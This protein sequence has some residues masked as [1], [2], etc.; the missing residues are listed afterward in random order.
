MRVLV[1]GGGISPE[2]EISLKSSKNVFDGVDE[3]KYQ[4]E[5]YDWDG[6]ES[7]LSQNLD[8]FDVVADFTRCWW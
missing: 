7:W 8:R 3:S 4:K 6:S 5:F 1:I 2:R